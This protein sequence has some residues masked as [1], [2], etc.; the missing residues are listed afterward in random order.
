M[1]QEVVFLVVFTLNIPKS[2]VTLSATM[3]SWAPMIAK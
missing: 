2:K 1:V 3:N